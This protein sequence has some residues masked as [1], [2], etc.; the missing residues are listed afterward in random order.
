MA[1]RHNV[2]AH[3]GLRPGA[4]RGRGAEEGGLLG[5]A[6]TFSFYPTKNLGALGDGGAVVTND[7][8]VAA[9]VASMR[10]YG[11]DRKYRQALLPARNSRLDEMQAAVLLAKLPHLDGWNA[12]PVGACGTVRRD[13]QAP[14]V[15]LP[16]ASG[17]DHVAHLYVVRTA[18]ATPSPTICATTACRTT[19]TTRCLTTGSRCS[20]SGS[21][22]CRCR[23]PSSCAPR[24]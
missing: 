9:R 4:R 3:R 20:A 17:P 23:S 5:R 12:Q 13:D 6:A 2:E 18:D 19:S 15:A 8:D 24:C 16:A 21:P 10:Q 14:K 1:A 22:T 11:W 7:A